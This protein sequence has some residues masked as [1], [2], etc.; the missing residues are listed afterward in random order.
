MVCDGC[1]SRVLEVLQ[2]MPGVKSANVDLEKGLAT[3]QVE[4]ASQIDAFNTVP[5]LI[6]AVVALG[7]EAQP[8]FD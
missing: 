3:V 7:F 4:A 8:H 6:E 5:Q 2:K 1:S